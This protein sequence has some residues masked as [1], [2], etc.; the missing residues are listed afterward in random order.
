[1]PARRIRLSALSLGF[2]LCLGGCL[3]DNE[4]KAAAPAQG[5]PA[6]QNANALQEQTPQRPGVPRGCTLEWSSAAK[7]SVLNCPDIRPPKPN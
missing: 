5:I 7:D 2:A 1:M 4:G 6:D 3:L